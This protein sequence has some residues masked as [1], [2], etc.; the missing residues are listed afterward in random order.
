[1]QIAEARLAVDQILNE[2]CQRPTIGYEDI[3]NEWVN[4]Y[5]EMTRDEITAW[6]K[7][8]S[9]PRKNL[10]ALRKL[11][12]RPVTETPQIYRL[13]GINYD[14]LMSVYRQVNEGERPQLIDHMLMRVE[15]GGTYSCRRPE[16]YQFPSFNNRVC[17]LPLIA[18]FCIRT[19]NVETFFAATA[20]PAHPANALAMMVIQ[21]E[22]TIATSWD[23]FSKAQLGEIP[24]WLA[25]LREMADR[26]TYSALGTTGNMVKNPHYRPGRERE[27]NQI[28]DS[29]D[30]ITKEC[31]QARFWYLKGA[32]Q[33]TIN[34]EIESDKTKVVS[35]LDT[36]GFDPVL[37][38]AMAKAEELCRASSDAFE[39]K[40]CLGHIRSFYEQLNIDAGQAIAKGLGVTVVDQW[41]PTLTFLKNKSFLSPQQDKFARGLYALL[42]DEGVHPLIAE[43]EF[44]RLLRNM[45]IEYGL[46]FL[47]MLEKKGVNLKA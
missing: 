2:E 26:Q 27:A 29:V 34:F 37:T 24:K 30:G 8:T 42:S 21:L 22:E 7:I 14:L 12:P 45:V 39:L 31:E 23:L 32:L 25:P 46:M 44:A 11:R 17:E 36:L 28:V 43:R 40:S 9:V 13:S 15:H 5:E 1:M 10:W 18:E 16:D 3:A 6:S 38:A 47:T 41:D 19:R 4:R 20:K 35:F 33:R